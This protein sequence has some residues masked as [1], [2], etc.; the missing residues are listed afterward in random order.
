MWVVPVIATVSA[1]LYN[2]SNGRSL[3][4]NT[5]QVN[6]AAERSQERNKENQ[7]PHRLLMPAT[8][9]SV[10]L[11]IHVLLHNFRSNSVNWCGPRSNSERP[12]SRAEGGTL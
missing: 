3:C 11:H 8:S 2:P 12:E 4:P 10:S 1:Q 7:P 5:V 6:C 9:E